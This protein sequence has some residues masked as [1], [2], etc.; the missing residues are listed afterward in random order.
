MYQYFIC[1]WFCLFVGWLVLLSM[2]EEK[3]YIV[4]LLF[5]FLE[6]VVKQCVSNTRLLISLWNIMLFSAVGILACWLGNAV[7]CASV[8][9]SSFWCWLLLIVQTMVSLSAKYVLT[10]RRAN[11]V[12]A[13][14]HESRPYSQFPFLSH[15]KTTWLCKTSLSEI[16]R[17]CLSQSF[18]SAVFQIKLSLFHF[19]P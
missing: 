5:S 19:I 9:L 18:L 12:L 8:T 6:I 14:W 13:R 15:W 4:L 11:R 10:S 1:C 17:H 3:L 2:I 7:E 16:K